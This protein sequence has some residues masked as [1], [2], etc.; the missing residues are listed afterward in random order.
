MKLVAVLVLASLAAGCS[1]KVLVRTDPPGA[2]LRVGEQDLGPLPP[3]GKE[4]EVPSGFGGVPVELKVGDQAWPVDLPRDRL[5]WWLVAA[6]VGGMLCCVPSLAAAGL[7]LANPALVPAALGCVLGGGNVFI[8]CGA[9]AQPSWCTLPFGAAGALIG[10]T[11]ATALLFAGRPAP[12]VVF[13]QPPS[14]Q[15]GGGDMAW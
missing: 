13:K 5:N 11:P 15:V 10:A 6:G 3:E 1:E 4:I 12:E 8:C 2:A 7:C 9:L 14:P